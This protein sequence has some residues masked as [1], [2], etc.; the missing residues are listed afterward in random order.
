MKKVSFTLPIL[1]LFIASHIYAQNIKP[2]T[3]KDLSSLIKDEKS[4]THANNPIIGNWRSLGP[5]GMP[6]PIGGGNT[7]GQ[8]QIHRLAFDS[9]Y[10]G[11]SNQTIYVSSYCNF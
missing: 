9:E 10:N 7:Y 1:L 4:I 2:K 8:G 3:R 6:N 5:A 11:Q